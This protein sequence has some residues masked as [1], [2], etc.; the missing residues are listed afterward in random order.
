MHASRVVREGQSAS[1]A[2][3]GEPGDRV[4]LFIA[5][6]AGFQYQ[7]AL[8]GCVLVHN[9]FQRRVFLGTVPGSGVLGAA[10]AIPELGANVSSSLRHVQ[11]VSIDTGGK[12]HLGAAGVLAMLDR[13]L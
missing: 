8:G 10:L 12:G 9:P 4:Y 3:D 1:F 7:A 11:A 5:V 6:D 2:F 13:A